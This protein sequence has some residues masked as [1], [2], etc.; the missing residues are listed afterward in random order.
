MAVQKKI[1]WE[2]MEHEYVYS[3]AK[4]SQVELAKKYGC[5]AVTI[6]IHSKRAGWVE[7]RRIVHKHVKE[8]A[9][10]NKLMGDMSA[11][12][13]L[14]DSTLLAVRTLN[15]VLI[16][17]SRRIAQADFTEG[18]TAVKVETLLG[19]LA[20]I[21]NSLER[22]V[23]TAYMMQGG[24]GQGNAVTLLDLLVTEIKNE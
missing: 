6:A 24:G 13:S 2:A 16:K 8:T 7:K 14:Q 17:F 20:Q 15:D 4:I 23:K 18:I 5:A 12:M 19:L 9:F 21:S 3:P 11:E 22:T 1:D 10:Q